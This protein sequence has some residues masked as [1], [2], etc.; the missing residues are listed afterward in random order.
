MRTEPEPRS[1][2]PQSTTFWA[3]ALLLAA[4]LLALLD[5]ARAAVAVTEQFVVP[6]SGPGAGV[7]AAVLHAV[8]LVVAAVGIGGEI[9]VAGA[10]R[11]GRVALITTAVLTAALALEGL[12]VQD[13]PPRP[14]LAAILVAHLLVLLGG[15]AAGLA[16][17]RARVLSGPARWALL[18]A[19][20]LMVLL[21]AV[22]STPLAIPP[23]L[24]WPSEY[25][26]PAAT[27][28]TGLAFLLWGRTEAV[29]HRARVI[30]DAW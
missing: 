25:L 1:P 16:V 10:R 27:L 14:V 13:V 30:H 20:L 18:A 22:G 26:V 9:G 2:W 21:D 6:L 24:T 4:G 8:A 17:V 5:A 7:A 19:A 23:L 29:K 15:L 3:G 28:L 12:P 11:W